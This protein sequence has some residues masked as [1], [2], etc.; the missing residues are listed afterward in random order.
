MLVNGN[1]MK[2]V[3]SELFNITSSSSNLLVYK[4]LLN[5]VHCDIHGPGHLGVR[6]C[7]MQSHYEVMKRFSTIGTLFYFWDTVLLLRHHLYE[8]SEPQLQ[9]LDPTYLHG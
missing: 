6:Y 8:Y 2:D 7:M 5:E 9:L 4:L 1:Q 3:I